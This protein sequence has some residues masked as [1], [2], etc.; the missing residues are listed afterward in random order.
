MPIL[1]ETIELEI[2]FFKLNNSGNGCLVLIVRVVVIPWH[3]YIEYKSCI[4]HMDY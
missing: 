1:H 3:C 2:L 4:Y